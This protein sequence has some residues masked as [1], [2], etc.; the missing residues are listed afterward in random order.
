MFLLIC[1]SPQA[2]A[3]QQFKN[4]DEAIQALAAAVKEDGLGGILRILG[5]AARD[6]VQ[7]G[8]SVA[9]RNARARFVAEYDAGRQIS[10]EGENKV[11]FV[12]GLDNWPFPIPLVRD[13]RGWR[14][15]TEAGRQ[16]ILFRRIGRNERN[17][18]Q[19]SLAYVDAQNEYAAM[20]PQGRDVPSYARRIVSRPG[21]KDGLYWPTKEG[22]Q[23]SPLGELA[24]TAARE[25]YRPGQ[26]RSPYH[27]YYY[28]ILRAQGPAAAGGAYGYVARGEMIG[29]FALVAY[30]AEYRN[31]GVMTFIV[32]HDGTVFQKDLGPRTAR[33]ASRM[34]RFNPDRS[35]QKVSPDSIAVDKAK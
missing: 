8:D 12:L 31:S 1:I 6:I 10:S 29:G 25:G 23:I 2:N 4:P 30:P 22:E 9:D 32:N 7:S 16:E 3:Q 15:D 27:G 33:L 35:W 13:N 28:R 21:K 20:N 19:V 24:A 17:A 18:I 5:P 14:F 26:G 34:T 11:V